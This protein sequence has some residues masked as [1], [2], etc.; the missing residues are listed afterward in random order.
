MQ[1]RGVAPRQEHGDLEPEGER[2]CFD[3][4]WPLRH[5]GGLH[6]VAIA[7]VR[8][9]RSLVP[10][11]QHADVQEGRD[12]L[13]SLEVFKVNTSRNPTLRVTRS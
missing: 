3:A 9:C 1:C 8:R 11:S 12:S 6:P 5:R 2:H 13:W 4:A 10:S 7:V